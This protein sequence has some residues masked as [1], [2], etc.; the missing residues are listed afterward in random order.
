MNT[1]YNLSSIIEALL[2]VSGEPISIKKLAK[3]SETSIKEITD[4]LQQ[5]ENA[6][7]QR[8]IHILQNNNLIQLVTAPTASK[9][10]E[11]LVKEEILGDFSKAALETL[12][13]IA[14][15][16][17]IGR[18]EIDYIRGVNSSFTLR[19]L[20]TR[21]L[22]ERFTPQSKKGYHYQPTID[23]MKFLGISSFQDLPEYDAVQNDI[24]R[25]IDKA[26]EKET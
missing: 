12:T 10:V 4:A 26:P 3:Y 19:N 8:G 22:V 7:H 16:H 20:I 9:Y 6:S 5:L 1:S 13:I 15:R 24:T 17:P 21:G 23:F 2:F 25:G 18:A 14:Y 11:K